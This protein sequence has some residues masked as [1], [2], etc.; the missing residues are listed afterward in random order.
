MERIATIGD[1][2]PPE[3]TPFE[4]SAKAIDDLRDEARLW[5]DRAAIENQDQA[6]GI[7]NLI[8]LFRLERDQADDRRKAINEP[9]R[10]LIKEN[11][12]RWKPYTD[13]CEATIDVLKRALL[14]WSQKLRDEQ[15][16]I[17]EA[18]ELAARVAEEER[19]RAIAAANPVVLADMET[20]GEFAA[21]AMEAAAVAQ[22]ARNAKPVSGTAGMPGKRVG[23]R[24]KLVPTIVDR[25]ACMTH[26]WSTRREEV[27][28]FLLTL[29][30]ED[31]R[32]RRHVENPIPGVRVD[33][34]DIVS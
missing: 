29:A 23:L 11:D 27:V 6:D 25:K 7:A 34:I 17:K 33:M 30:N 10:A 16:M 3:P 31:V 15:R 24:Q 4:Q 26:Y 22:D 9:W 18:A 13:A 1:N 28:A 32:L 21:I 5:L 20:V 2:H 19:Q 14:P 8:R 12:G